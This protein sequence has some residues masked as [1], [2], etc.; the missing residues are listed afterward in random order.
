MCIFDQIGEDIIESQAALRGDL[1]PCPVC[2]VADQ[3]TYDQYQRHEHCSG[4]EQSHD[5]GF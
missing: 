3:L 2:G 1:Y 5:T 4:C